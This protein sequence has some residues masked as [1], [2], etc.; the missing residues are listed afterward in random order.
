MALVGIPVAEL[1]EDLKI[2]DSTIAYNELQFGMQRNK[3]LMQSIERVRLGLQTS[4]ENFFY[5][6]TAFAGAPYVN[7]RALEFTML[8]GTAAAGV[9]ENVNIPGVELWN[10]TGGEE[11]AGALVPGSETCKSALKVNPDLIEQIEVREGDTYTICNSVG[12]PVSTTVQQ[13][14][15]S[16]KSSNKPDFTFYEWHPQPKYRFNR[17]CNLCTDAVDPTLSV[18]YMGDNN[19]VLSPAQFAATLTAVNALA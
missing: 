12:T 6:E 4:P 19:Y 9:Y 18:A 14:H 17:E 10:I 13:I 16:L 1:A 2:Q 7:L 8:A 3:R 5:D 11:S 15:L